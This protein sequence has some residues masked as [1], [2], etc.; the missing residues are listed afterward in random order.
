MQAERNIVCPQ[1]QRLNLSPAKLTNF[2]ETT[3]HS[4]KYFL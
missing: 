4:P 3:H 1:S 2:Y